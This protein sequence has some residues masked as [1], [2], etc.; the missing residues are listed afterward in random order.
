MR[1]RCP[2]DRIVGT[3]VEVEGAVLAPCCEGTLESAK[4]DGQWPAIL[5]PSL[6][7]VNGSRGMEAGGSVWRR[8]KNYAALGNK[9]RHRVGVGAAAWKP[10]ETAIQFGELVDRTPQKETLHQ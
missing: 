10:G 9:G 6:S 1:S 8:Q 7:Q 4:Q 5:G 2:L 3:V